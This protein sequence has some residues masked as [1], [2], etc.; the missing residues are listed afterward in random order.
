METSEGDQ[1]RADCWPSVKEFPQGTT[2]QNV[3]PNQG[4]FWDT[5]EEGIEKRKLGGWDTTSPILAHSNQRPW[6]IWGV[7]TF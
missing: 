1:H 2:F 4:C 5:L 6:V 3:F 7:I